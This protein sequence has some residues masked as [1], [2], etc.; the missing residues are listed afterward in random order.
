MNPRIGLFHATLNAIPGAEAVWRDA[1]APVT[2]CHYLDEGLLAHV[3]DHGL[4]DTARARLHHWLGLI[5]RD[6][7]AAIMTTCSSLSPALP[8]LRAQLAC[9]VIGID[10]AMIGEALRAGPRIG[11]VATLRSAAETT[12]SLLAAAAAKPVTPEIRL[13]AGAF[14]ALARGDTATHDRLVAT[15][16]RAIA[17][18]CD[19]VLLAQLSMAR[20]TPLLTDLA[21]PVLTSGPGAVRRTL[22]AAQSA[23]A[24]AS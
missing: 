2:L 19:I 5:A 8:A 14:E 21:T 7:V 24:P 12:R 17:P 3:R 18:S 10:D 4:D 23:R 1:A 20:A 13:A 6:G 15:A 11:I 22:L 9:P 16:V